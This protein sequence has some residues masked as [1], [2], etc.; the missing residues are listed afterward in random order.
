MGWIMDWSGGGTLTADSDHRARYI[1]ALRAAD[2]C[3]FGPLIEFVGE[4]AQ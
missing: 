3:E 2:G 1:T 4:I